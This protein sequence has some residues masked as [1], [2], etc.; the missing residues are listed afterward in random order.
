VALIAVCGAAGFLLGKLTQGDSTPAATPAAA[1]EVVTGDGVTGPAGMAW[2]PS[3]EFLMGSDHPLARPNERPTQKVAVSGFWMDRTHVTNAE[4]AGF[5]AATRYVTTAERV[6]DW[7]TLRVQVPPD[8]PK[9]PD[10]ALVPGAM[11]FVGTETQVPLDDFSQW[12]RYVPGADWRHPQG[13]G[14]S[15]D[16]KDHHPVVQVSYEDVLAYAKWAG[17]RLPT[18][19]EW[20]YA[21]R[22]GLEQATYAWG[23]DFKPDGKLM[24][25]TWDVAE[26][27]FPVLMPKAGGAAGTSRVKTF[28][29]NGYGLYDMTGNAWQ[30]VADW[31]RFDYFQILAGQQLGGDGPVKNPA[32]PTDSY[33]PEDRS[34]PARAPRRVTRGGSFLCNVDYCLSYRPS[35][36][37]GNDP[38]NPMSHIGFRLVMTPEQWQ[39]QRVRSHPVA[40]IPESAVAQ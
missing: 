1:P 13:P 20:E 27:P 3:G 2:V 19:A 40:R 15:I 24:A 32:G 17:K 8:T 9:P 38:Y 21:A 6:P 23:N 29:A 26:R 34:A 10:S 12:W 25:N 30:W 14:S 36:R 28:P 7:E 39:V 31:Y 18:E 16:G 37:R 11:V 5:V 4:F 35:A 33:D 22:G